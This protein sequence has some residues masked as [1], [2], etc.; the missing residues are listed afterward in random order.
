MAQSVLPL[1]PEENVQAII[2]TRD[3]ETGRFLVMVTPE[4]SGEK[5]RVQGVRVEEPDSGGD[6]PLRW[7]RVGFCS[8][9]KRRKRHPD[10][11]PQRDGHPIC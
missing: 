8:S 7:R 6:Q 11:F 1:G 9:D 3:Y 2:D 4:R 5:D 10:L